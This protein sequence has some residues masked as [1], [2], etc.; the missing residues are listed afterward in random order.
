MTGA[1][2]V[3]RLD[4]RAPCGLRSIGLHIK[5]I[6]FGAHGAKIAQFFARFAEQVWPLWS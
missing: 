6:S 2:S 1:D 4:V 5:L 3:T